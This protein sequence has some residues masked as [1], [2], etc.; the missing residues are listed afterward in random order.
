[1]RNPAF[2]PGSIAALFCLGLMIPSAQAGFTTIELGP[3]DEFT[4]Q[5]DTGTPLFNV[6]SAGNVFPSAS[7]YA[8]IV[9]VSPVG[10]EVENGTALRDAMAGITTA[11][12]TNRFLVHVEPGIY[13]LAGTRLHVKSHVDLQGSGQRSTLIRSVG[14]A[15]LTSSSVLQV[16]DDSE[17][18]NLAIEN[19]GGADRATGYYADGDSVLRDVTIRI[20][21]AIESGTGL[22]AF[23]CDSIQVKGVTVEV[24]GSGNFSIG[25]DFLECTKAEISDSIISANDGGSINYGIRSN[26]HETVVTNVTASAAASGSTA[27]MATDQSNTL[28]RNSHLSSTSTGGTSRGLSLFDAGGGSIL[29][30]VEVHGSQ[31]SGQSAAANTTTETNALFGASQLVGGVAGVGN[32]TCAGVYDGTFTF[33]ASTCP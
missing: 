2:L 4:V 10:T 25:A 27:G 16:V 29:Y 21:G 32:K 11:S 31:I 18:R 23:F 12:V 33:F 14:A 8:R 7:G 30:T 24:S 19:T 9:I 6:D 5:N 20:S 28:I 1:M 3:G 13:D 17:V 15:F 26:S 22:V